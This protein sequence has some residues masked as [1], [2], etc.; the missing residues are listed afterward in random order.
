[1]FPRLALRAVLESPS[2]AFIKLIKM[3]TLHG[4]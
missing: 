3:A 2:Q 1:M 4:I